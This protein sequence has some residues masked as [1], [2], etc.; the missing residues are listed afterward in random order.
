M[1]SLSKSLHEKGFFSWYIYI[2]HV[3]TKNKMD[4]GNQDMKKNSSTKY[5]KHILFMWNDIICLL[6]MRNP[7]GSMS[8]V[9]GLPN[10]S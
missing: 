8:Q 6:H 9:V 2:N 1:F 3:R 4:L 10:N 7:G 5:Y